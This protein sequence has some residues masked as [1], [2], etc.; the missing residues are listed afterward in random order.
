MTI[1]SNPGMPAG[2]FNNPV[3]GVKNTLNM[4]SAVGN[5]QS[6]VI[7]DGG[8]IDL[9][10]ALA[11]AISVQNTTDDPI[12]TGTIELEGADAQHD[13]HCAPDVWGPID[14]IEECGA[15]MNGRPWDGPVKIEITEDRPILPHAECQYAFP[16]P[17]QFLRCS[18]HPVGT[19]VICTITRFKRTDFSHLG[20]FGQIPPPLTLGVPL[21]APIQQPAALPAGQ[22][23]AQQAAQRRRPVPAE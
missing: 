4:W 17:R 5:Y 22:Q 2:P 15:I 12:D 23:T 18:A 11:Y 19:T 9:G 20:P 6:R 16:C 13:D 10:I 14:P 1:F 21:I 3:G 7:T 8:F